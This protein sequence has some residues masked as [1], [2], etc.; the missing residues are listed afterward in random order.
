MK[1]NYLPNTNQNNQGPF[2]KFTDIRYA[3]SGLAPASP[4]SL[5]PF[6]ISGGL[7]CSEIN[8]TLFKDMCEAYS[9]VH[10]VVQSVCVIES[11]F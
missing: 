3:N 8:D 9:T 10:D 2:T 7:V 11:W 5:S 6:N 1:P 4:S